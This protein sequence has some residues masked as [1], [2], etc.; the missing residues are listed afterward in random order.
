MGGRV[1]VSI[2]RLAAPPAIGK[3]EEMTFLTIFFQMLSL[4]IMIGT[5][6]LAAEKGMLDEHCNNQIS[7]MIVDVFN[8]LLVFSSAV[9]SVGQISRDK[10]A[11]VGL[12]AAC[13][14]LVFI[15]VGMLLSRFFDKDREQRKMFQMMFVFSNLG[16]IGMPVGNMPL[17]LS[18]QKG[19]DGSACSA[20][21][22]LTTVLCVLTVPI[23]L[24]VIG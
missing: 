11:S 16:F 17:M 3:G 22:I 24:T 19:I 7:R 18:N 20:A 4:L 15:L 10:L 23:L 5:G 1:G 12:I 13:M 9:Q 8:P 14:F 2:W 6:C 21:I